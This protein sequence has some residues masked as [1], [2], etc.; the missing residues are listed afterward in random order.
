MMQTLLIKDI[1]CDKLGSILEQGATL[2]D[3]RESD[4]FEK[5]T[6]PG[7][8]HIALSELPTSKEKVPLN[9]TLV[10]FCRSGRRS[11]KAAKIVS[12]WSKKQIFCLSGGYKAYCE[13]MST[14]NIEKK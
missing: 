2:V 8:A 1:C 9:K 12:H 13:Y 7:A 4:E 6:I 3:V 14:E 11:S 10:L 5:G